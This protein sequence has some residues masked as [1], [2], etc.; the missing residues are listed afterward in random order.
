M[1]DMFLEMIKSISISNEELMKRFVLTN[2]EEYER[3]K[4]LDK[5]IV[6]MCGHYASYEWLNALQLQGVDYTAYGIYKKVKNPY[7]DQLAKDI[8]GKFKGYLIPTIEASKKIT[9]LEKAGKR[10][11]YAMVADQ[12]P[13]RYKK[14][15]WIEFMGIKAPVFIGSEIL[16]RKLDLAVIYLKVE[17]VKRG[18]YSAT[19]VN[20]TDNPQEEPEFSITKK[21]IRLLENQIKKDPQ[22]Y[23]W[24]HKRWKHRNRPITQNSVVIE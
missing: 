13:K 20:I 4:E 12:S 17:K 10:G 3:I 23:L 22:F 16:A 9:A 7:F 18:H 5:S 15:H 2:P 14:T 19:L 1:C 11:I 6:A 24:T 21:Y 8:R